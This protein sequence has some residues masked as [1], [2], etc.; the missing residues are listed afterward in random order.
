M[1][2]PSSRISNGQLL[3]T[4]FLFWVSR[5]VVSYY[6]I[7]FDTFYIEITNLKFANVELHY[8]FQTYDNSEQ[9]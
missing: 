5:F 7:V 3:K 4:K 6:F 1:L 9:G 8:L 2:A